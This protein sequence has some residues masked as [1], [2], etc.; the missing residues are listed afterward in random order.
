MAAQ[1]PDGDWLTVAI[2]ITEQ[3]ASSTNM[4]CDDESST[5]A[6]TLPKAPMAPLL[7]LAA[8]QPAVLATPISVLRLPE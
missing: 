4:Y 3:P 5:T 7:A 6:C 1:L 2:H 8:A